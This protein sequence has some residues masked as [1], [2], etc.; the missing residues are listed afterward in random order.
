MSV[1]VIVIKIIIFILS[2]GYFFADYK[3]HRVLW[4]LAGAIALG[5]GYFMVV[6]ILADR[7]PAISAAL[8][9]EDADA[10][11]AA[12]A[13]NTI[14][15]YEGY[16]A[17]HPD[18][19]Y[20]AVARSEI[21]AQNQR[22]DEA[23]FQ[24]AQKA[25]T[26][27][28]YEGYLA[29]HP[30]G[31]YVGAARSE[32]AAGNKRQDEA[33]F[34]AANTA[35]TF[36]A[37]EAYLA[38]WPDGNHANTAR[39]QIMALQDAA[40]FGAAKAANTIDAYEA[41]LSKHQSGLSASDARVRMEALKEAELERDNAAWSKA[42]T[43]GM[44]A[45]AEAYITAFPSGAHI[46]EARMRLDGFRSARLPIRTFGNTDF[47]TSV[48]F[49]ADGR[50]AL[51]G[52]TEALTL[53]DIATGKVIRTF[54]GYRGVISAVAFS[55][56]GRM[57]LSGSSDKTLKLWDITTGKEITTFT[58]HKSEITS[59]TF[60]PD[61]HT[62]MS[63]SSDAILELWDVTTGKEVRTFT[64]HGYKVSSIAFS[65]DG[66]VALSGAWGF[67][68]DEPGFGLLKLWDIA[69]GKVIRS[70]SY[71]WSRYRL[72]SVAFSPDGRMAVAGSW[73]WHNG[74]PGHDNLKL[75]DISGREIK[76]L[77]HSS[78]GVAVD[79]ACVAF[80]PDGRFAVSSGSYDEVHGAT[81]QFTDLHLWDMATRKEIARI[82]EYGW[83][84]REGRIISVA[85][86][87]D[88]RFVLSGEAVAH[89]S[90]AADKHSLALWD[91]SSL[92][93]PKAAAN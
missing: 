89:S 64:G 14:A 33:D 43:A 85:F 56:D 70:F 62:A 48:A 26:V 78:Q 38:K 77:S 75:W 28:A 54:T 16:L 51:T 69:T 29:T 42:Q 20:V 41:Y 3:R 6:D 53:W 30:N 86:S 52:S 32:I 76:S 92:T 5:S 35:K 93:Q 11:D 2:T 67:D 60:S 81:V 44:I 25:N 57:A 27:A 34:K 13:A 37:Y 55:P 4:L 65:P 63:G 21:A 17:K 7:I 46:R 50:M 71:D 24:A 87:P 84:R 91:I 10:F 22:Q 39:T 19:R 12:K 66:N 68:S 8:N 18:G 80:S 36:A 83:G 72:T 49:S 82:G 90:F 9:R 74:E 1:M 88:S 58:G 79:V 47:V 59:V 15:A 40:D 23:D 45:D 73:G 31:R 61:G